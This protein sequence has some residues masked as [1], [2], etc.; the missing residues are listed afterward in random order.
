MVQNVNSTQGKTIEVI[1]PDSCIGCRDCELH[2]PDFAIFVTERSSE[3][4]FA[5]LTEE[6]KARALAVKNNKFNKVGA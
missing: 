4:K 3:V 6:S 1:E 5:K 2:C